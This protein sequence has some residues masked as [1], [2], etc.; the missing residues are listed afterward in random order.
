MTKASPIFYNG[1]KIVRM[2]DLPLSQSQVFSNW[3]STD[4]YIVLGEK[5][6]YDCVRYE[7]YEYWFQNYYLTAVDM[8]DWL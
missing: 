8:D 1:N 2:S 6:D 3:V 4:Q 7:D 5:N